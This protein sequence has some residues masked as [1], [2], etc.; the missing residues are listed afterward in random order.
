MFFSKDLHNYE[1][2]AKS[3]VSKK[4]SQTPMNRGVRYSYTKVDNM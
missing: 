1:L 3:D 2:R 4:G